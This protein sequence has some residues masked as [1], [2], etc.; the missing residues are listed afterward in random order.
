M[1]N[2]RE[3]QGDNIFTYLKWRGDLTVSQSKFNEIDALILA[4]VAYIPF[5]YIVSSDENNLITIEEAAHQIALR[6]KK[7]LIES[8][9]NVQKIKQES[10]SETEKDSSLVIEAKYLLMELAKTNRFKKMKLCYYVDK[11][12][13]ENVEQFSAVHICV[14]SKLTYI[15]FRG[16]ADELV[17][18]KE[19]F[20]MSYM[21]PVPSQTSAVHYINETV[22]KDGRYYIVGGHSKGGNLAIYGS[23]FCDSRC[24]DVI[25]Q[26]Y[27]FDGPG[28][29]QK[30]IEYTEYNQVKHKILSY[31]P[32]A[33]IVGMLFEH[34][35]DYYVVRCDA[36]G[37]LQ[38]NI[39]FWQVDFNKLLREND[40]DRSSYLVDATLSAWLLKLDDDQRKQFTEILFEVLDKAGIYTMSDLKTFNLKKLR[41]IIK[42]MTTIPPESREILGKVTSTLIKEGE[43]NAID[44]IGESRY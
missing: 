29:N 19:D 3:I 9:K 44:N 17:G 4:E 30:M 25:T 24:Q 2:V 37:L 1:T 38:H 36:K 34:H 15:A 22:K 8:F 18:W 40:R 20:N 13:Y 23:V 26:I 7:N 39:L 28:F 42:A 31:V 16:T 11:V 32:Q 12:D 41:E 33:S 27:S 6:D 10:S 5:D 43:R 14:S 35:E 21:M